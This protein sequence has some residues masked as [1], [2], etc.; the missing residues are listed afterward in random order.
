MPFFYGLRK[1]RKVCENGLFHPYRYYP[2]HSVYL[3]KNEDFMQIFPEKITPYYMES[4]KSFKPLALSHQKPTGNNSFSFA[5][6]AKGEYNY[7]T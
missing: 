7:V 6:Q 5:H 4:E 3:P 1:L 2:F